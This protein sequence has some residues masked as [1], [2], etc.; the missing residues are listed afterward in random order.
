VIAADIYIKPFHHLTTEETVELL[1][2]SQQGIS[3]T[4]AEQRLHLFGVNELV[5]K[6]EKPWWILLLQQ[7]ADFM[8][9]LLLVA[10]IVSGFIGDITDTI[11]II[12]LVLLNAFIGFSQ[13]Y[14][15][16][17][18]V[19]A[20]KKMA[21]LNATVM[22]ENN[23]QIIPSSQLVP[24]DIL[25]LEAGNV[26]PADAR[27]TQAAQ[28]TIQESSLTG[29]AADIE[30]KA[31]KVIDADAAL[32][33][34]VNMVYK[35]TFITKGNGKA[36]VTATGMKT[37]LG[38]IAELL[39]AEETQTPL[40]KRMKHF[41]KQLSI[42]ILI[43]CAI[44]FIVDWLRGGQPV[45][46]L[47]TA[48]SLA[49][50]AIPEALPSVITI[51]L[52]FGAKKMAKQNALVKKLPAV[53]TLGSV[54]YI[55]TDKTGTLT[56]NKMQAVKVYCK[57]KL[58][59]TKDLSKDACDE[60]P[61][62]ISALNN[63]ILEKPGEDVIGDS[64][65]IALYHFALEKKF[66]KE[67]LLQQFP[68][69]HVLPFDADRKCMTTIHAHDNGFISF[70]KGGPD[71]ILA[72]TVFENLEEEQNLEEAV[73][74]MASEGLR[75]IAL[76]LREWKELPSTLAHNII[77]SHLTFV[78][79]IGIA[80]PLRPESRS[81]VELCKT[82][83]IKPIMITGDHA[84]TA[85]IIATQ[86][87]IIENAD[88]ILITSSQLTEM[89]D[90][91][92]ADKI[93]HVKA[94]ARVTP[95]Q[96]LRIVKTL[97]QKGEFVAMTGDGVND[98][99]ALQLAD[100]GIAM[101]INGTDVS[102]EA[103]DMILLDDNF[104]TIVKAVKE[105]RRIFDNIRKF[106]RYVMTGNAG[107][108]WTIFLAPFFGLP[109]PLLPIHI[110]WINLVTDG[111]PGLALAS[112]HAE[113]GIMQRPPR[114]ASEN[115]FSGGMGWQILW[116]GFLIGVVCIITQAIAIENNSAHWQTMVFTVLCFNQL[117]NA[118]AVR[119]ETASVFQLGAMSNRFMFYA[120]AIT[121]ALQFAIV[122]VPLFNKIF[123][124]QPLT[125]N[126][127]LITVVFSAVT[128]IAIEIEK[129]I[130]RSRSK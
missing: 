22:R 26:V 81:A 14:R 109:V 10:A 17:N 57:G 58:Y 39:H 101:G 1:N 116:A 71:V 29:E 30:K 27:L 4:D 24:G 84:L 60:W 47:L 19:K 98:A 52:S 49:V 72:K 18:A 70:T 53:E 97:Q 102:K 64:T 3:N 42:I 94:L 59:E 128:F 99:P 87:G 92:L 118:M 103:A 130:R 80:D 54:T 107:E 28:L 33:E 56:Q 126:E 13:E 36:I 8:I 120:I 65:E 16:R 6:E 61:F 9:I 104:S 108:V 51:A 34:R 12:I 86:T 122:Y 88:D 90:K 35:G 32:G 48:I 41:S 83:G 11:V 100:I 66:H 125:L 117:G 31:N 74:A 111:L 40:Q 114:P 106:I 2:S 127:L 73:N 55:C 37:E 20:L 50:A 95:E 123:K 85:K 15:A 124:T 38:R 91:V 78:A 44:I 105:G 45:L 62:I 119:S 25:L 68:L 110:L 89:S 21:A 76:A 129:I 93:E 113:K 112:E 7:F 46:M 96:K 69:I 77:E 67:Q 79:L 82:A 115:I 23:I 121:V 63:T 5:E 75:T 43:V